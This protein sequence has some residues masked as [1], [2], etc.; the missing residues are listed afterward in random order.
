MEAKRKTEA[1]QSVKKNSEAK[2]EAKRKIQKF[3]N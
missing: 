3:N 1:K 2:N